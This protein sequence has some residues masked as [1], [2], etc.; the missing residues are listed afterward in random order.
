MGWIYWLGTTTQAP[1]VTPLLV[2]C[3]VTLPYPVASGSLA[4]IPTL[5]CAVD[6]HNTTALPAITSGFYVSGPLQLLHSIS[7]PGLAS[8]ELCSLCIPRPEM[9]GAFPTPGPARKR[10]LPPCHSLMSTL[11]PKFPC[12]NHNQASG[13]E[14]PTMPVK[15]SRASG[16]Q[17]V[18]GDL[19]GDGKA[20][21]SPECES[22]V[23]TLYRAA[24]C[25]YRTLP[26]PEHHTVAHLG[27]LCQP[28]PALA[29]HHLSH[30]G[31]DHSPPPCKSC[32]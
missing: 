10:Q 8:C 3:C 13:T 32:C 25:E 7:I 28:L 19:L 26:L 17:N 1:P 14:K 6:S 29:G 4:L 31:P 18:E 11:S 9:G 5:P 30:Q 24:G 12:E 2:L 27:L 22:S 20:W 15:L 21:R 16:R 23:C